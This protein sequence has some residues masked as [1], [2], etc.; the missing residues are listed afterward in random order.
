MCEDLTQLPLAGSEQAEGPDQV[1]LPSPAWDDPAVTWPPKNGV[2]A[3]IIVIAAEGEG[4]LL[5]GE[6]WATGGKQGSEGLLLQV[7]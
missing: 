6:V 1:L 5:G 4:E 3:A 2:I 7:Q